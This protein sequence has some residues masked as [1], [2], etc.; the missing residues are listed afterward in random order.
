[1]RVSV[2]TSMNSIVSVDDVL[3][4]EPKGIAS[5]GK[6]EKMIDNEVKDAPTFVMQETEFDV[7]RGNG[8]APMLGTELKKH[9]CDAL[10]GRSSNG[11][12][13]SLDTE[14]DL[15]LASEDP[16]ELKEEKDA[17]A[18]SSSSS[19]SGKKLL[20]LDLNGLLADI[21]SSPPKGYTPDLNIG[22]KA[23]FKRP[24]C[25]DFLKFCLEKF[26]VGI[27]SGRSKGKVEKIT[28]FLFGDMKSRLLFCWDISHCAKI[29]Y[30]SLG[31]KDKYV[32]FKE[33]KRLW[34]NYDP[35][36]PWKKGDF[37][38]TNTVLLDDSPFKAL[39][40]P[41]YTA[42]FPLSYDYNDE[43][44]NS[45]GEGGG[46][47]IYLE[48][49][50]EADNVQEFIKNHPFGQEPMSEASESWEFYSSIIGNRRS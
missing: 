4:A 26:E 13:C 9:I 12:A 42:V 21:V 7:D 37:S 32:A 43:T 2:C 47:R 25:E 30:G 10:D 23:I 39:L 34:E 18:T 29:I 44:D 33:L 31:R 35:D 45:L 24:F 1:M 49:L 28:E 36:L 46:L 38:E 40:N 22:T 6:E 41:P 3:L 19:S 5:P 27:W 11:E 17:S 14:Q 48:K 15:A 50:A 16:R 20:I 8:Q